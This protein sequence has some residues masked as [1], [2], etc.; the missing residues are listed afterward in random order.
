MPSLDRLLSREGLAAKDRLLILAMSLVW[1]GDWCT[2]GACFAKARKREIPRTKLEEMLL[3]AVLFCGF[4]RV[5]SA[6]DTLHDC[7]PPAAPPGGGGLEEGKQAE[8]GRNLFA[9]VYGKNTDA[10]RKMLLGYHTELHDFVLETAYGR[11]L[12]RP[13][14][15]PKLRELMAVGTLAAMDQIPQLVAHGRGALHFAATRKEIQETIYTTKGDE[16][17]ASKLLR[18]IEGV[19]L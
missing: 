14:L 19:R 4:P 16:G 2:L 7:W 18:K 6:F 12:T 11:I 3:Q 15:D 1:S 13:A 5:I 10:V 17:L 8:A 9:A